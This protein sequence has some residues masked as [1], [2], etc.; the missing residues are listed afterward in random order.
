MEMKNI[1]L[2]KLNTESMYCMFSYVEVYKVR[3]HGIVTANGWEGWGEVVKGLEVV[4]IYACIE[5]LH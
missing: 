5:I 4:L 2:N 3:L 1:V